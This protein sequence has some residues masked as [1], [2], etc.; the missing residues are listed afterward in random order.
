MSVMSDFRLIVR[1]NWSVCASLKL[2]CL[3][4]CLVALQ[5]PSSSNAADVVL[6]KNTSSANRVAMKD[7]DHSG[8]DALLKKHVNSRGMVNYKAWKASVADSRSLT[9]YINHLSTVRLGSRDSKSVQLAFWINAYNAVTI[10]GMLREYPTSSI[11]NHTAKLWGYNIWKNLKLRVNG[12]EYS[13]EDIEH[14][15]LREKGEPRIHFAIVCASIGCPRLLNEAYMSEKLED[16]LV[17]NARD[18][19]ADKTKFRVEKSRKRVHLSP[20]LSW[21]AE[22]FGRGKSAQLRAIAPYVPAEAQALLL[23]SNVSVKYLN[24]DW[25]INEQK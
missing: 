12:D 22:D 20:I 8:W 3:T 1:R 5:M 19:F 21:F 17:A 14:K 11:R 25:G 4:A 15:I 13:L 23:S 9:E 6:G 7:I 18:F 10:K 2:C 16:Q 24:Y